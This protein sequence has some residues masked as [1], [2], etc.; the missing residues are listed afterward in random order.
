MSKKHPIEGSSRIRKYGLS[1]GIT[2]PSTELSNIE[3]LLQCVFTK[4]IHTQ[5]EE[6]TSTNERV[7]QDRQ[8]QV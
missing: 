8:Y 2:L 6:N 3:L 4:T 7:F 5:Q 1:P